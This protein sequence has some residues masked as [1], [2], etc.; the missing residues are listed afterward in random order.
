MG[1]LNLV[2]GYAK[3]MKIVTATDKAF[4][5]KM[6]EGYNPHFVDC[7]H[8]LIVLP[9]HMWSDDPAAIRA[10]I[11]ARLDW[12]ANCW[13]EYDCCGCQS[14]SCY[15]HQVKQINR[16]LWLAPVTINANY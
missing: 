9:Q 12:R 8:L 5:R 2:T 4:I 15:G 11:V 3:A 16:K 13:H 1:M 14:S 7:Y 10:K 6:S